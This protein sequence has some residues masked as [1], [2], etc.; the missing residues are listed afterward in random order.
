MAASRSILSPI[1]VAVVDDDD[2][3]DWLEDLRNT[4]PGRQFVSYTSLKDARRGLLNLDV[5]I[6]LIVDHNMKESENGIALVPEVRSRNPWGLALP[7]AYYTAFLPEETFRESDYDA[8]K[9]LGPMLHFNKNTTE[10]SK[11]VEALDSQWKSVGPVFLNAMIR[12]QELKY[13]FESVRDA[14]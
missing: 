9:S 10:I 11:V 8:Y 6:G 4:H 3:S 7:I 14:F 5:P 2:A 13:D 1:P 12:I